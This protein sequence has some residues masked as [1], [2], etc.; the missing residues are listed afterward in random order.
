MLP[1]GNNKNCIKVS[2]DSRDDNE[3]IMSK[4]EHARLQHNNR[5]NWK[6]PRQEEEKMDIE[7]P[8]ENKK[9]SLLIGRKAESIV[10]LRPNNPP[11][12][13]KFPAVGRDHRAMKMGS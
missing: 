4:M 12:E 13:R 8:V 3:D 11:L 7:E 2:I 10:E 5:D 6:A 9:P 1:R